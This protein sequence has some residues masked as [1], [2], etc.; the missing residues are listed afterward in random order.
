MG[1]GVPEDAVP[2]PW[3]GGGDRPVVPGGD[4]SMGA[5]LF[6]RAAKLISLASET[7]LLNAKIASCWTMYPSVVMFV[8]SLAR[9]PAK[10]RP[11][12]APAVPAVHHSKGWC[13]ALEADICS[14]PTRS[15]AYCRSCM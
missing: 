14:S 1:S 5:G 12:E 2:V 6:M 9:I 13:R 3:L 8:F 4:S 11:A 15:V 10:V 7:K